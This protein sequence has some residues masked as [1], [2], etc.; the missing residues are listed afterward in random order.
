MRLTRMLLGVFAVLAGPALSAQAPPSDM[1][2]HIAAA[3]AAA[4]LDYRATFVNLC[5]PGRT[6]HSRIQ[7]LD[8]RVAQGGR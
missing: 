4:G 5:Y 7:Q 8:A 3:K 2:T 6:R 1:D